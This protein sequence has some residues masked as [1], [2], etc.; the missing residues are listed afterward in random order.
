[1]ALTGGFLYYYV[2]KDKNF[3]CFW[4]WYFLWATL[5]SL[6][7]WLMIRYAISV[8]WRNYLV[9]EEPVIIPAP[10]PRVPVYS[11][12]PREIVEMDVI[13]DPVH[14]ESTLYD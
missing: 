3:F 11:Y 12:R 9:K 10:P 6:L 4:R 1:M 14:T 7:F 5:L 2:Y 8:Q 13:R